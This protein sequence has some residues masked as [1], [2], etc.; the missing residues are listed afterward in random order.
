ML[1]KC[2]LPWPNTMSV[3]FMLADTIIH[4]DDGTVVDSGTHAELLKKQGTYSRLYTAQKQ[5]EMLETEDA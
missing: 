1:A 2:P 4:I 5:L 3:R